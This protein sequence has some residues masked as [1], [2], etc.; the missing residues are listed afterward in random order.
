MNGKRYMGL[1]SEL[2]CACC[3]A[4]PPSM[5][6]HIRKGNGMSQRS[7]SALVVPL[8][9]DCHQGPR[10]IHGDRTMMS[11]YRTDELKMLNDTILAVHQRIDR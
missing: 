11:I 2:P 3:G 1:V 6:H 5:V 4:S 7:G 8:C 9:W 10:G